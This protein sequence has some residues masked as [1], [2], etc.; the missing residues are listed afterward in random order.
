MGAVG[1][2][3]VVG[4]VAGTQ[5]AEMI[6]AVEAGDLA[7]AR[8]IDRALAPAVQAIMTRTQGVIMVKAALELSGVLGNRRTRLPLVEATDDEVAAL[9]VDL[10]AAG[11]AA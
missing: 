7:R 6:T 9:E 4:H 11:L 10:T 5:Y 1:T 2:V 8:A 3:S